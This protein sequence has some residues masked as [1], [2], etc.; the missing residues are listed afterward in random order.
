MEGVLGVE[1]EAGDLGAQLVLGDGAGLVA[2]AVEAEAAQLGARE[3]DGVPFEDDAGL[4]GVAAA[5]DGRGG[6]LGAEGG[7]DV[8]LQGGEL[9][10][11]DGLGVLVAADVDVDDAAGVDV[12]REEDG[13]E[14]DLALGWLAC[15]CGMR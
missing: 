6:R 2:V 5:E 4:R 8:G 7:V 10:V 14:L 11:G 13:G 1:G 12:G 3:V 9:L 15:R